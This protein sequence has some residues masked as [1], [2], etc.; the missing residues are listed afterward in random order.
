MPILERQGWRA[1]K[2]RRRGRRRAPSI[3]SIPWRNHHA[4][5]MAEGM[6]ET[7][8][9]IVSY[10][11]V[12]DLFFGS[13]PPLRKF[14]FLFLFLFL[15]FFFFTLRSHR[16]FAHVNRVRIPFPRRLVC[17]LLARGCL[18]PKARSLSFLSLSLS[19]SLPQPLSLFL[20]LSLSL[21]LS[22]SIY[23]SHSLHLSLSLSLSL[24]L[25]FSLSLTLS[26]SLSL[27]LSLYLSLSL[28][29]SLF[30]SLSLSFLALY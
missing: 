24:P 12:R 23:L 2:W 30:I 27:L 9:R 18:L 28:S 5:A 10:R 4:T 13:P 25:P 17:L 3:N 16:W 1:G 20:P 29:L 6:G 22:H 11:F 7:I 26:L 8:S 21:Y 19:L 14:S 15:F